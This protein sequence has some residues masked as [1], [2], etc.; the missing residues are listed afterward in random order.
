MQTV[1]QYVLEKKSKFN[2]DKIVA[3]GARS[4]TRKN[5]RFLRYDYYLVQLVK[6]IKISVERMSY[7]R[8]RDIYDA[9]E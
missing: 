9:Y 6:G 7:S 1:D 4:V 5:G 3:I 8:A 2:D